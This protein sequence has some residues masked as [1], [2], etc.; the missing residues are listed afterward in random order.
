MLSL[1]MCYGCNLGFLA[2][3]GYSVLG[4]FYNGKHMGS[5]LWNTKSPKETSLFLLFVDKWRINDEDN[6]N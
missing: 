5:L 3:V 4:T 2:V 1:M 6:Q